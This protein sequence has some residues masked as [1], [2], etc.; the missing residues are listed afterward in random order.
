MRHRLAIT[1]VFALAL[2]V[3]VTGTALA[4]AGTDTS[5]LTA[6]SGQGA[7]NVVV[8]ANASDHGTFVGEVT[9]NVF[10]T[11]PNT[12]FSLQRA[13]DPIG[14]GICDMLGPFEEQGTFT[15]ST[16][17]AGALHVERHTPAPSGATFDVIERVV[18][19]D[20]TELDSACM[21]ITVK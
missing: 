10:N 3:L 18:G 12:L 6:V 15:T 4:G 9:V 21:T 8:A 7:G 14:D 5:S 2:C 19:A 20:G 11:S 17:G 13:L 16:G 1:G